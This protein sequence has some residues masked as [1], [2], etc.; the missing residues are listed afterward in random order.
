MIILKFFH[1]QFDRRFV[2]CCLIAVLPIAC[3]DN[4]NCPK[5]P[6]EF[7]TPAKVEAAGFNS[8]SLRRVDSL[9]AFYV[10]NGTMANF[11]SFVAR[12]GKVVHHKAYGYRDADKIPLQTDDIFRWASQTKAI[13]TVALLT[14][15]EENK[16]M[17]DDPI[18]KY[19]PMFSDPQVYVSGSAENG[20]LVTRPAKRKI[21]VRHL[22]SHSSGY[23]YRSFGQDL[24]V[25]HYAQPVATREVVE[26]IARTPLMHDPGEK[27]TYGFGI[28]IAGHLA[29]VLSGKNLY[30]LMKERIFDPL[31]MHDTHFYL[32]PEKH[33]RLVKVYTRPSETARYSI[34]TNETEQIYPLASNQPYHGGGAGLCGTIENYARFCQMILNKGEFNGKR[35]LGRKTVELMYVNQLLDV[36]G[37]YRFSLGFEI[38]SHR[39]SLRTMVSE[40][41]LK[42]GGAYGTQYFIDPKENMIVLFYTNASGWHNPSVHDRFLIS[43][44]QALK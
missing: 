34:A 29:E 25:I 39:N 35:I 7:V 10:R 5:V 38:D 30:Q 4:G 18:D 26:R 1:I 12:N 28:D 8:E 32:P 40:G 20:D 44:Y 6:Q 14:L 11:A 36:E 16:F 41:T 24:Q 42:W 31:E 19:L 23:S 21:T 3:C 17:L 22:L 9:M 33:D 13:T 2:F 15:F 43:V 27:F 37:T